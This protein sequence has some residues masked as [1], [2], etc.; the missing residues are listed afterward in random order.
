MKHFTA[1][2]PGDPMAMAFP[3]WLQRLR[4]AGYQLR[5]IADKD[6]RER[7]LMVL[8]SRGIRLGAGPKL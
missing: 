2:L 3:A 4:D 6:A 5:N 7:L 1:P 8:A